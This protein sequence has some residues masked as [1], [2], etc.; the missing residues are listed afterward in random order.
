MNDRKSLKELL[1][2]EEFVIYPFKGISM[3]PLLDEE[4]DLVKLVKLTGEPEK[5]DVALFERP[6]GA[7]VLHRVIEVGEKYC[8]FCGDN[9]NTPERVKRS[10]I[11]AKAVGFFKNGKYIPADD[12]EYQ[13]YVE[14][15]CRDIPSRRPIRKIPRVWTDLIS[16]L[17]AAMK[18][19]TAP[20]GAEADYEKLFD[21]AHRHSVA[22]HAFRAVDNSECPPET[23][24][25]WSAAADRAL[26]KDILFDA[27]R[28]AILSELDRE[29]IKYVCLKGIVIKSLYPERGMREFADNDI[30]F[31]ASREDDICKI[32]TSRGYDVSFEPVHDLCYKEPIYNFEFHKLLFLTKSRYYPAFEDIWSRVEKVGDGSEYKMTIADF[33]LHFI[34]HLAKHYSGGGT[35]VR[36]FCDLYLIK[37]KMIT[38]ADRP[39]VKAAIEKAGLAEFDE[40]VSSL[41]E[42]MFERADELTF[43]DL[44]YIMESGA[45]GKFT[46]SVKNEIKK[47]GKIGYFFYRAFLPYE[48]MCGRFP[49]LRKVPILLPFCYV[50]RIV[51]A[52]FNKNKRRRAKTEMKTLAKKQAD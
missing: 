7:L 45:Y 11:L 6:N 30:L 17:G 31:D 5:Y 9:Q 3:L 44:S 52:I 50:A 4:R 8:V 12:E 26:K 10:Q 39:A 48:S 35:G 16:L 36:Y 28:Q 51:E 46:T 15:I 32:M 23:Y 34:A 19:E 25:K 2:T 14:E 20:L 49:I 27:E 37:R 29:N 18:G 47:R 42:K 13:K 38:E 22:S 24:K 1:E 21:F 33:Y 43:D 40:K 41:S